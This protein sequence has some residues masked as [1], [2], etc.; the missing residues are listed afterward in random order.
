M[1]VDLSH[2]QWRSRLFSKDVETPAL[3]SDRDAPVEDNIEKIHIN[4]IILLASKLIQLHYF[5]IFK[6]NRVTQKNMLSW[7][8]RRRSYLFI[9]ANKPRWS[10][11]HTSVVHPLASVARSLRFVLRHRFFV[12]ALCKRWTARF[13]KSLITCFRSRWFTTF[14]HNRFGRSLCT[15]IRLLGCVRWRLRR[16]TWFPVTISSRTASFWWIVATTLQRWSA[17]NLSSWFI[18]FLRCSSVTSGLISVSSRASWWMYFERAVKTALIRTP[19]T[20]HRFAVFASGCHKLSAGRSR[21]WLNRGVGGGRHSSGST[22][23]HIRL[24]HWLYVKP[25]DLIK[26]KKHNAITFSCHV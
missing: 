25:F 19:H 18:I 24:L 2:K 6:M 21:R 12:N 3:I 1:R 16:K 8:P 23:V 11:E 13:R 17:K 5:I 9:F 4:L 10:G 15:S 7:K 22:S 14:R 26:N 20:C